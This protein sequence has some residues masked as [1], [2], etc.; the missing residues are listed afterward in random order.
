M[1][2]K[3]VFSILGFSFI[4]SDIMNM[5]CIPCGHVK[6]VRKCML[7]RPDIVL[8]VA[9]YDIEAKGISIRFQH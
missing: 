9:L 3:D 8:L 5:F 2:N 1:I 4:M 6:D 7:V